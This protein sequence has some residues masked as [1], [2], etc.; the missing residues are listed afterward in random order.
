MRHAKAEQFADSD[1]ERRLEARGTRDAVDAGSWLALQ[2][3]PVEHALVSSA[4]RALDTWEAVRE[5]AAWD[6]D[7]DV[8][9]SLYAAGTDTALDV[10]RSL[11]DEVGGVLLVGHNPTVASLA[12]LLDDGEG[13]EDAVA[14]MSQGFPTCALVV[15]AYDGDWVD[16]DLGS[17]RVTGFHV[18]RA[19]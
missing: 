15:L 17:A 13:D 7:P 12:Q 6:F 5:G 4:A 16:L 19:R 9:A 14:E 11:S 3:V 8:D 2:E 18:G 1:H 10:L